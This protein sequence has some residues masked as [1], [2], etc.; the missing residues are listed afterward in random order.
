MM[1]SKFLIVYDREVDIH[2][3][4]EALWRL[5]TQ[6][7]PKRDVLFSEGPADLLD[8][9]V[10]LSCLGGKMGI[11]ATR[12]WPEEGFTRPWPEVVE[13]AEEISLRVT[14]RWKDYGFDT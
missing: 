8:H 2:D 5:G 10:P 11:D 12:K 4:G 13:M 14:E 9:V 3:Y 6:V 1:F 7:D